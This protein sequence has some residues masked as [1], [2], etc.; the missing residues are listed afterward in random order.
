VSVSY[1]RRCSGRGWICSA[2]GSWHQGLRKVCVNCRARAKP[3]RCPGE[4]AG[5]MN[6]GAYYGDKALATV[7]KPHFESFVTCEGCGINAHGT[8]RTYPSSWKSVARLSAPQESK[9]VVVLCDA[10]MTEYGRLMEVA[11]DQLLSTRTSPNYCWRPPGAPQLKPDHTSLLEKKSYEV[12]EKLRRAPRCLVTIPMGPRY[13]ERCTLAAGHAGECV[14]PPHLPCA[15]RGC[16]NAMPDI[17]GQYC[18]VHEPFQTF[19]RSPRGAR[20]LRGVN[21]RVSIDGVEI[22]GDGLSFDAGGIEV[23]GQVGEVLGNVG[24]TLAQSVASAVETI[25]GQPVRVDET[26]PPGTVRLQVLDDDGE[27]IPCPKDPDGVHHIGCGC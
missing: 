9:G 8:G 2:C 19:P 6:H 17:R 13:E 20:V 23:L 27:E 12:A 25:F 14:A 15:Q 22:A 3:E 18:L 1:C 11:L 26:A 24:S 4:V 16:T 10:C 7:S 21:A 5:V